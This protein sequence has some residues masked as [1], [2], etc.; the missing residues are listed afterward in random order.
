MKLVDQDGKEITSKKN[1]QAQELEKQLAKMAHTVLEPI[2]NKLQLSNQQIGQE[3]LMQITSMA[4]QMIFNRMIFNLI[5]KVGVKEMNELVSQDDLEELKT[6][7]SN[8][9][10]FGSPGEGQEEPPQ[11]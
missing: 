10:R 11:A 1:E 8:Q 4:H 9:F 5:Q 6:S 7:F 2:M 3:Q